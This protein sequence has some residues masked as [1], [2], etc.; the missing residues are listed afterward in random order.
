MKIEIE[1]SPENK[2][3]ADFVWLKDRI[4]AKVA[5]HH[6][7]S[8]LDITSFCQTRGQLIVHFEDENGNTQ[9]AIIFTGESEEERELFDGVEFSVLKKWG[10]KDS[11]TFFL[12]NNDLIISD[13]SFQFMRNYEKT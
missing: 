3:Q 4:G 8:Q 12:I 11:D 1:L 5:I 6:F 2:V 10:E 13:N 9:G 7:N